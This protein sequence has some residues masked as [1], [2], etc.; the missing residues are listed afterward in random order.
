VAGTYPRQE[1]Q[2]LKMMEDIGVDVVFFPT[3]ELMY[4]EGYDTYVE[5]DVGTGRNEGAIRPHFFRGVA[6]V[7]CKLFIMMEPHIVVFGQKDAQ[8]CVVITHMVRDLN[9]DIKVVIHPTRREEDGLAMSSRN[10]YLT[11]EERPRATVIHR[12]LLAGRARIQELGAKARSADISQAMMSVLETEP[13]LTVQYAEVL[14][15]STLLDAGDLG[16]HN[17]VLIAIAGVIGKTRLIDNMPVSV[18]K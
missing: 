17:E 5:C 10:K 12:A 3:V 8:Q 18:P 6:T 16:G 7:C 2:D 1:E 14:H 11:E 4:P 9:F 13:L 15:R